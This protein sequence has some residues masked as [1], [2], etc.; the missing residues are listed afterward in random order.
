MQKATLLRGTNRDWIEILFKHLKRTVHFGSTTLYRGNMETTTSRVLS[1]A[2]R[3]SALLA[4]SSRSD[5]V[6]P[7]THILDLVYNKKEINV[8]RV[9]LSEQPPQIITYVTI[10]NPS[11]CKNY[12]DCFFFLFLSTSNRRCKMFQLLL[13]CYEC[14]S[15]D[16]GEYGYVELHSRGDIHFSDN[17]LI[18][19]SRKSI[20]KNQPKRTH[21][22]YF[23]LA[24][25][26]ILRCTI[27][28]VWL[29]KQ[30]TIKWRTFTVNYYGD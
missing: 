23:L 22:F 27:F 24:Y 1:I 25:I 28:Y 15:V 29:D 21:L 2:L 13:T 20:N 14:R 12:P 8:V 18:I 17:L 9:Y 30:T 5:S 10:L 6:M 4:S 7:W 19:S 26:I 16:S 11:R 3:Y